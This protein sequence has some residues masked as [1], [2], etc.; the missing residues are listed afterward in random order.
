MVAM[1]QLVLA[2]VSEGGLVDDVFVL[3]G[4]E[5]F[6]KVQPALR[7]RGCEERKAV[8]A[9]MRAKAVPSLMPG[10]RIVNGQPGC[11]QKPRSQ[12]FN[13]FFEESVLL[14][15]QQPH[16]LPLGDRD[17]QAGQLRGQPRDRDLP[18]VVLAQNKALE[19]QA[20]NGC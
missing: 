17:A 9:D 15:G 19:A 5:Q 2:H 12:H 14:A 16:D 1:G 6:E 20:R 3:P 18:L 8:I 11:R 10:A 13:G 7:A 4:P